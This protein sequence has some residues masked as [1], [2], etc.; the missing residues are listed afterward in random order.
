MKKKLNQKWHNIDWNKTSK[1]VK[2]LQKELVVVYKNND[3]QLLFSLQEKL[4]MSFEGRAFAVRQIV[5]NDGKNTSGLDG[6]TWGNPSSKFQA[7]AQ[8]RKILVQ[9]SGGYRAGPVRRKWISKDQSDEL[10]PLGIPNMIDRALQALVLMCLDPLVEEVSDTYSFGFRKYRNTGNAIQ[11]IRTILDKPNGPR[12]LW[13]VNIEKCFDKISHEFLEKETKLIANPKAYEYI[14]KW[15][16]APIIDQGIKTFPSEGTPQGGIL[17]PLLC[18]IALNG[19]ENTV[20]DGLPSP[21]SKEGKKISGSWVIR[22]ADDFIVT[23]P[24]KERIVNENI[25]RVNFFLS[26]RDLKIS[27]KKSKIRNL[28]N[29]GFTF[30]GWDI[31]LKSRNFRINKSKTNEKVLIIRPSK[32]SIK[33]FKRE[34]KKNFRSNKPIQAIIR[35]LNP[36][37]RSWTN[38]YR[39]SYHSQKIFQ[40][41]GDY[42]YQSW[43]RW[44]QKKHPNRNKNWI[45]NRYIFNTKKNSW[46]I[47]ESKDI[48]LFDVIQAK[49]LMISSLRN[50][51]NP[52]IDED[53]YIRRT[54]IRDS[55]RFRAAI[56][57]KYDFKCY[58]CEQ[59][60]YGSEEVHLHHLIPRKD[61]GQYTLENIVP[62]HATCHES[63]TYTRKD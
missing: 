55:E 32:K 29:E 17:S 42:I 50:N 48:M 26:K 35:D 22:Y 33:R 16:K 63:I 46:R 6:I 25:P 36:V 19:L 60:L 57:K 12:Y 56:Y 61:G 31:A 14:K 3:C 45:Y 23:S 5:S 39:D 27:E 28:N 20:R 43:W 47:G 21:N 34:I 62:V 13:N 59:A 4:M 7:I 10:R 9:K 41:I 54:V 18:N 53:Y 2:N 40:S 24:C 15:L 37:L 51:V 38:Y 52:Y 44:A 30:L 1:Y 49:Q 8:L 58:V 11:R